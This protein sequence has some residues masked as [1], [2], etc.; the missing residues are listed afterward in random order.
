MRGFVLLTLVAAL[1]LY[2][3]KPG[4]AEEA[5]SKTVADVR[6]RL[7]AET[8]E[9]KGRRVIELWVE[10]Y[11]AGSLRRSVVTHDPFSFTLTVKDADGKAIASDAQRADITSAPQTAVLPRE[12]FLRFPVTIAQGERWNLD[13]TTELWKL[14]PGRYTLAGKY[15]TPPGKPRETPKEDVIHPW[16]GELELPEI[17]VDL[18]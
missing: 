2:L 15:Q 1:L 11:N 7:I 4:I 16:E 9:V 12:C 14:K 13:I 6:G 17:E 8:R 3:V 5:W 18:K 10:L